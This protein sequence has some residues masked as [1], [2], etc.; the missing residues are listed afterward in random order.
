MYQLVLQFPVS[1]VDYNELIAIEE[2]LSEVIEP[3]AE[4]DGH[5]FGSGE[6]NVFILTD[7]PAATFEVLLA[8]LKRLSRD[9]DVTVA[10]REMDGEQYT[11]IWPEGFAGEFSVA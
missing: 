10:Y 1:R 2:A 4:V 11:V 5:D 8:V 3:P 9:R 6:G 7:D